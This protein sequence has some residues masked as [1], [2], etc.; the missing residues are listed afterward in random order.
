MVEIY[1]KPNV[2][3]NS[4]RGTYEPLERLKDYH[5]RCSRATYGNEVDN[6][7]S[8]MSDVIIT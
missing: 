1:L 2:P 4:Q 5:R 3:N 8:E 7:Y 6:L